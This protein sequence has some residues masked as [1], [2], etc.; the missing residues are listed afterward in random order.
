MTIAICCRRN[1]PVA[2]DTIR[3]FREAGQEIS[4]VVVETAQRTTL[5]ATER[6]YRRAHRGFHAYLYPLL[7]HTNL[8]GWIRGMIP[9]NIEAMLKRAL[10]RM[11]RDRVKLISREMGIPLVEVDRHS[12]IE[13]RLLLERHGVSYVLLASSAWL[14]REPLLS[15]SATR[16]INAHCA[17]LPRH[18]SLDS[19]P[20]SVLENDKIGLTAHFV[21]GG[22]DTGPI[23][24]FIEVVPQKGDNLIAL[25]RRVD[26]RRPEIFLRAVQGLQ[27][28]H[29]NPIA[30][31]ECEGV[32]HRPMTVSEL[33]GAEKVLQER[34]RQL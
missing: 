14:V 10:G 18:R 2:L 5:S 19:L 16:I 12:S 24:L 28:G 22:I 26:S 34:L 13:T 15:M 8:V 33:I 27:E 25:R 30:Q 32:H 23:L 4:L 29:I 31:R 20:W 1:C 6:L 3:Y 17:R 9:L 21:D 7:I 11:R